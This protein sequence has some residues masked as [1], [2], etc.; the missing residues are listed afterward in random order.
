MS[1]PQTYDKYWAA[2]Y[3]GGMDWIGNIWYIFLVLFIL[4]GAYLLYEGDI[5]EAFGFFGVAALGLILRYW[6]NKRGERSPTAATVV[7]PQPQ[8]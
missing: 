1:Q 5:L 8:V 7:K 3:E 4:A 2:N 6:L